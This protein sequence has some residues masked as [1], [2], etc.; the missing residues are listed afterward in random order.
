MLKKI[1]STINDINQAMLDGTEFII[2][3]RAE[4]LIQFLKQKVK[5]SLNVGQPQATDKIFG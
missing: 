5:L 1:S 4:R 3:D 2:K